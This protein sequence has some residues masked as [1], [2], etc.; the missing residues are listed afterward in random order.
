LSVLRNELAHKSIE[1]IEL[2]TKVSNAKEQK[3]E[4]K[5][6]FE[7]VKKDMIALKK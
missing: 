2:E 1:V 5:Q 3:E 6:K 4:F 7:N